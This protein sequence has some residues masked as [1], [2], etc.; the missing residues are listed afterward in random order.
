VQKKINAFL[1]RLSGLMPFQHFSRHA[2]GNSS[3]TPEEAVPICSSKEGVFLFIG[4]LIRKSLPGES[5]LSPP[6]CPFCL[7]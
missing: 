6:F 7:L 4:V 2:R 1:R 5:I 3:R